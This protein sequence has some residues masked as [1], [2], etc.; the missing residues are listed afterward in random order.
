M[1]ITGLRRG[2]GDGAV[3]QETA[4][5]AFA[6]DT[7]QAAIAAL[8]ERLS[9]VG[10]EL[11]RAEAGVGRVLAQPV[12]ADRPSPPCDVS[13]MDGYAIRVA[14]I[15]LGRLPVCDEALPGKPPPSI[16][17]AGAIRIF[18]G[19]PVP[20]GADAVIPREDLVELPDGIE[21]PPGQGAQSSQHIRRRGENC[22]EGE[23][24]VSAG[25]AINA[26]AFAA[27]AA[28]GIRDVLVY[29]PIRIT[30]IVTGNEIRTPQA[31]VEPWELR[32]S[33]G[34]AL[35]AMFGRHT[36]WAR[37]LDI[38]YVTDDPSSLRVTVD[39]LLPESDVLLLTGGVSMGNYDFVPRIV[40]EA[41][42]RVLFH[43]LP[44]RPG[45]PVL[46]AIGPGGQAVLGLPGNPMAALTMARV[47][48]APAL[49]RR[50][51][52]APPNCPTPSVSTTEG[53][54]NQ[55]PMY[56]YKPV[57]ITAPGRAELVKNQGS[58]DF[59]GGARSDGFIEMPPGA[60]GP[61]PWP[62]YRWNLEE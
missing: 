48:G 60:D 8:V 11:V 20:N 24:V 40:A 33:N 49:R 58:A 38:A 23:S 14:D 55:L 19:G 56:C 18:T 53:G 52:F 9:P 4:G 37:W 61:G 51:G 7:P 57:K 46:G 42:C 6:F 10:T 45:K 31:D 54:R 59:V 39:R 25:S 21:L 35:A 26:P 22:K 36:A 2:T 3:R 41:G 5:K 12:H 32:D 27:L 30:L 62:F 50:A 17:A 47:F 43:G 1:E 15:H 13:A 34:P 29:K 28:F 44:V 16:P